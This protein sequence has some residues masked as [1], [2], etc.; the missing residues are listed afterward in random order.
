M[1]ADRT[2]SQQA[3][4]CNEVRSTLAEAGSDVWQDDERKAVMTSQPRGITLD[5]LNNRFAF[6]PAT[7]LTGPKHAEVRR[8]CFVLAEFLI[9]SLPPGREASLAITALEGCMMWSNA[10]IARN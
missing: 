8:Q 4:M 2:A 6:H 3:E 9:N 1:R 10:A 7:D 5:D